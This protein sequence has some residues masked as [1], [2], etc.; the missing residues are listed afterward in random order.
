MTSILNVN[1]AIFVRIPVDPR[2][3]GFIKETL[4]FNDFVSQVRS[5][6]IGIQTLMRSITLKRG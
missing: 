3:G 1:L 5:G 2:K 6:S 4:A